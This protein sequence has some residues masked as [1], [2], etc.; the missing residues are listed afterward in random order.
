MHISLIPAGGADTASSRIRVFSLQKALCSVGVNAEIGY[1]EQADIFF[2]QKK[3]TKEILNVAEQERKKGKLII[4]DLDDSGE[5]LEYWAPEYLLNKMFGIAHIIT[6]DT[7][8][9]VDYIKQRYHL[10]NIYL[11][12]DCVDYFP[13]KPIR[14]NQKNEQKL[15][16]LWFGSYSNIK[17]FEK[18]VLT[19]CGMKNVQVVVITNAASIAEMRRKYPLVNCAA[20]TEHDF[21]FNLQSCDISC[22]MHDDSEINSL[23]SN[24]R[25][26]TSIIWGVPAVVSKTIEYSKTAYESKIS[27]FIFSTEDEL[28][29]VVEKLRSKEARSQYLGLCQEIIWEKY[30]PQAVAKRFLKIVTEYPNSRTSEKIENNFNYFKYIFRISTIRV[31]F[32]KYAP[33]ILK[34]IYKLLQ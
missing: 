6:T 14:Q 9:R 23:K 29:F 7:D 4:Y 26:I 1:S 25:M 31:F 20:W 2:I 22:L 8:S 17:L 28:I 24:N 19:L 32:G 12:P 18:Y 5:A 10:K 3:L 30:S 21:I 27:E 34:D 11:L 15:K 16:V 13:E 33:N